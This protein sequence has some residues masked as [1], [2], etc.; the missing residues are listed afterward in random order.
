M[1]RKEQYIQMRKIITYPT[2]E[3]NQLV[4]VRKRDARHKWVEWAA[5][6]QAIRGEYVT[7]EPAEETPHCTGEYQCHISLVHPVN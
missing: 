4:I 5:Y 7:T 1:S 6:V 3:M 2:L